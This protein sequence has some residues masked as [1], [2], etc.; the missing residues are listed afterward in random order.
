MKIKQLL[1]LLCVFAGLAGCSASSPKIEKAIVTISPTKG[2][3]T[4]GVVTFTQQPENQLKIEGKITG[5]K[6]GQH[7]LHIHQWGNCSAKDGTSAG[8]HFNPS[9][10]QH[11]SPNAEVRHVGDLGNIT[12]NQDGVSTFSFVVTDLTLSGAKGILG[13]GLIVH[14][15]PDDF[16]SQPTGAAG[17]RIGCGVVGI[18]Q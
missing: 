6:P 1:L 11:G 14:E 12:A 7:G 18:S 9:N 5:I 4:K 13:R 8:G 10:H 17:A 3:L 2:H 15:N 16:T